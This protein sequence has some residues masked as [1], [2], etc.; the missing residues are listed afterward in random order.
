MKPRSECK[1]NCHDGNGMHIMPCCY[2]DDFDNRVKEAVKNDKGHITRL[3][4][5]D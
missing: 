1:C 2:P 3:S 5:N 4:E